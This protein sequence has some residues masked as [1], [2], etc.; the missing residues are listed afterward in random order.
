[1][2]APDSSTCLFGSTVRDA[3]ES[4][5]KAECIPSQG[6]SSALSLVLD[7]LPCFDDWNFACTDR[8]CP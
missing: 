8:S 7:L 5:S 1:M 2:D 6:E 3:Q 4:V